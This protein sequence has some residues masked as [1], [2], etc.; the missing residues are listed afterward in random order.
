MTFLPSSAWRLASNWTS[1]G[2]GWIR[3]TG[4]VSRSRYYVKYCSW[5]PQCKQIGVSLLSNSTFR[6][7]SFK[8]WFDTELRLRR[9]QWLNS[10]D[11][12][13]QCFL[14][15]FAALSVTPTAKSGTELN[16]PKTKWQNPCRISNWEP[17]WLTLRPTSWIHDWLEKRDGLSQ[18]ILRFYFIEIPSICCFP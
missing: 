5:I 4:N 7:V 9:N 11:K 13:L 8:C 10:R 17:D 15:Q 16:L 18:Q 2:A 6:K 14:T 3:I 12:F 1:A